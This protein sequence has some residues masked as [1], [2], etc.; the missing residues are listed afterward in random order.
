MSV[1]FNPNGKTIAS[2]SNDN[3]IRLWDTETGEPIG[4]PLQG[5]KNAESTVTKNT[6]GKS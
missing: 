4:E 1:L 5:Q 2:G 3:T 6:K